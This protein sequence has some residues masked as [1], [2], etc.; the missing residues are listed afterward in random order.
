MNKR[1]IGDIVKVVKKYVQV[2]GK[3]VKQYSFNKEID[4]IMYST[5]FRR[6]SAKTQ[7]FNWVIKVLE[8]L[9]IYFRVCR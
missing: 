3:N 9:S 5:A 4:N 8:G 7:V 2:D 6:M 1:K